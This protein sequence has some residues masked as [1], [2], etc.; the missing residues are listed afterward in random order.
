MFT[1]EITEFER[2]LE[3]NKRALEQNRPV[4]ET[5]ILRS[6]VAIMEKLQEHET[7]SKKQNVYGKRSV[8]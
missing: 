6:I 8:L 2:L 1:K 3:H 7:T 4:T 5:Q